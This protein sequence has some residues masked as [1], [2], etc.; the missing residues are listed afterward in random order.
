[1]SF[2]YTAAYIGPFC[3]ALGRGKAGDI[4]RFFFSIPR[5][6]DEELG[7]AQFVTEGRIGIT[8]KSDRK[9]DSELEVGG[10]LYHDTAKPPPAINEEA[11]LI[12]ITECAYVCVSASGIAQAVHLNVVSLDAGETITMDRYSL[13][14]VGGKDSSITINGS[15]ARNG[16]RI[17]YARSSELTIEARAPSVMGNFSFLG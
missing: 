9:F 16:P 10:R 12:A 11:T 15:E 3:I 5:T 17:I 2:K 7:S 14:A 1:M 13:I 4:Q 8:W 6:I